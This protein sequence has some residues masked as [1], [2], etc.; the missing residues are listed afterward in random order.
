MKL[1]EIILK[2]CRDIY[3]QLYVQSD[4]EIALAAPSASAAK[5]SNLSLPLE[6]LDLSVRS[7][8]CLKRANINTVGDIA[9]YSRYQLL[10]LRNLGR[11]SMDE[12]VVKLAEL[13]IFIPEFSNDEEAKEAK[14]AAAAAA[15]KEAEAEAEAWAEAWAAEEMEAG[16][17][18]TAQAGSKP[19]VLKTLDAMI[20]L[21]RVKNRIKDIT[22]HCAIR[23]LKSEVCGAENPLVPNMI[24]LGNPGTG[25]TTVAKL[26]AQAFREIGLMRRG[27]LVSVT[28]TDLVAEY[29][30]QSAVKTTKIFES[31]L[32]GVLFVDE[33]YSL[34]H[35][36]DSAR[37][38]DTFSREVID[39]LTALM[40]EYAGRCCVIFAGYN[41]EMNYMLDNANPGLRERFPFKLYFDD[42]TAAELQEIFLLKAA[43]NKLVIPA[44]CLTALNEVMERVCA[45]KSQLFANGR[46][47]ENFLQE[48]TLRQERRLFDRKQSGGELTETDLLTLMPEDFNR[49]A[50]AF[51]DDAPTPP[52]KRPIGFG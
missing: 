33:A 8:N 30:G 52:A 17:E 40:T 14:E 41:A 35:Q 38:G 19:S 48:V 15:A 39:T 7:F 24:F 3:E 4:K 22:A 28:R 25:K 12:I 1:M 29:T 9:E 11:K 37:A 36:T 50:Q 6:E 20:G 42:Y 34:Y 32:D 31:A 45:N 47:A 16:A 2:C 13:D 51:Q 23:K 49:A 5:K 46:V 43:E 10:R 18:R 26:A 44:E 21:A 27:H